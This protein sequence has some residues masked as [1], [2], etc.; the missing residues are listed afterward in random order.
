MSPFSLGYSLGEFAIISVCAR[1][2]G[3]SFLLAFLFWWRIYIVEFGF[4]PFLCFSPLLNHVVNVSGEDPAPW[5]SL[6]ELGHFLPL[7]SLFQ[8]FR[9]AGVRGDELASWIRVLVW[10]YCGR[11]KAL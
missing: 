2:Y 7:C 8:N 1:C 6:I 3:C 9:C 11:E 4:L 5:C 10:S